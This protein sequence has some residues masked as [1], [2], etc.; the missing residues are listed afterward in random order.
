MVQKHFFQWAHNQGLLPNDRKFDETVTNRL[1]RFSIYWSFSLGLYPRAREA[2]SFEYQNNI[3]FIDY[4]FDLSKVY[5]S[6][7]GDFKKFIDLIEY[8]TEKPTGNVS[9]IQLLQ[10]KW[11]MGIF[12]ATDQSF[13]L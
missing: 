3:I 1:I 2:F 13:N 7:N 12:A 11:L 9:S 8:Q 5:I 10:G 6:T 4:N